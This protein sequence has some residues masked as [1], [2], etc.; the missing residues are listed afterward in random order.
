MSALSLV[1]LLQEHGE[2]AA[3]PSPFTLNPG[4]IIWTWVVFGALF[5]LLRKFVWP[6]IVNLAEEREKTIQGQLAE[7]E[8]LNAE[9]RSTLEEHQRLL[10]GAKEEAAQLLAE[11]KTVA[12]KER[13]NLIAKAK[14]E[15]EQILDRAKREIAAERERA[16]AELRQEAVDLSLAAASRLVASNL[17]SDANRKL[18]TDYLGSIGDRH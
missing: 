16:V 6:A 3:A 5:L 2:G 18:V 11:A 13:E 1:F 14:E 4:L 8:K 7:A 15:Q 9:A 17:D 10:G 12:E